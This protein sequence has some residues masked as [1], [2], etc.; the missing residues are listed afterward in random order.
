[1]EDGGVLL[2]EVGVLICLSMVWIAY[3]FAQVEA[4][5]IF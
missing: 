5:I 4:S 3:I 2:D 1:M